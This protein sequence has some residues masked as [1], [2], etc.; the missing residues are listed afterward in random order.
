M[1]GSPF[2]RMARNIRNRGVSAFCRVLV[3]FF[4]LRKPAT[5]VALERFAIGFGSRCRMAGAMHRAPTRLAGRYALL[6]TALTS[7]G[8]AA[9]PKAIAIIKPCCLGDV[10]MATAALRSLRQSFPGARIDFF[11]GDWSKQVLIG[12][13]HVDNIVSCGRVGSGSYSLAEYFH[14]VRQLRQGTYDACFVLERSAFITS[15]PF[16]AGI[17]VRIG[18][19][20]EGRGFSLGV[21]VPVDRPKHEAELYLDTLRAV[22]VNPVD[23]RL[24]FFP[25]PGDDEAAISL[26][27]DAGLEL[28]GGGRF[29]LSRSLR[30]RRSETDTR[31]LSRSLRLRR[32]ETDT[33]QTCPCHSPMLVAIHPAGGVNPGMDFLAKRWPA[34]RFGAIGDRLAREYRATVLIVGAAA[35]APLAEAMVQSMREP[36]I[37]LAGKTGFGELAAIFRRCD[38]FVGNDTGPMH[39]AV[40][41]ETPI[42]AIFGPSDERMYGPY[43]DNA[44]VVTSDVPCRPCFKKGSANPCNEYRCVLNVTVE[45]VWQAVQG[46]LAANGF[47]PALE[48]E[49]SS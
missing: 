25:L 6:Q 5:P 27:K 4:R 9:G 48:S 13:P 22:G 49:R 40:A 28:A 1:L 8:S 18:L 29:H 11:V 45:Q 39:L 42:V 46:R 32:S 7:N 16:L 14:L 41:M 17:P 10:L 43:T 19:D 20:S 12:N 31:H 37:N 34:E 3:A 23:P 38:L 2:I 47:A 15:L 33:R 44:S 21:R 35:D 30:L 24:E 26:L 36:A